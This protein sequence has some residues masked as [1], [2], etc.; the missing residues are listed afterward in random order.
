MPKDQLPNTPHDELFKAA[1][2]QL[3]IA[4][5]YLSQF[6]PP[7]LVRHL[8]LEKL[9]LDSNSYVDENLKEYFSDIVYTCPY[10]KKE[11]IKIAFLLEHKSSPPKYPHLQLLRYLMLSALV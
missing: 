5:D 8:D 10:G 3:D 6:L 11:K 9:N 7:E 2:S 4:K 1:F